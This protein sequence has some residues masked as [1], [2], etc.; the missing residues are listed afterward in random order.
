MKIHVYVHTHTSA[1][2]HTL[3]ERAKRVLDKHFKM[4]KLMFCFVLFYKYKKIKR[5]K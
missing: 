3:L 1:H 2:T 4:K 5:P